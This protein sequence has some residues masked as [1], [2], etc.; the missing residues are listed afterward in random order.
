MNVRAQLFHV[1]ISHAAS[2]NSFGLG[3][4]DSAPQVR[5][6]KT[7][8]IDLYTPQICKSLIAWRRRKTRNTT[9][10]SD[11]NKSNSFSANR[12]K[13]CPHSTVY[14]HI[15]QLKAFYA[16]TCRSNARSLSLTERKQ[17]EEK[18]PAATTITRQQQL[19]KERGNN[20]VGLQAIRCAKIITEPVSFYG[21]I[22]NSS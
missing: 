8:G 11:N 4:K 5:I 18:S 14:S 7:L 2:D 12:H 19:K 6:V 17:Q 20:V 10:G 16:H 22:I 3:H 1:R 13:R 15:V 21:I 9:T